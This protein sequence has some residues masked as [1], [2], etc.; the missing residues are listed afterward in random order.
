MSA[1]KHL[2]TM[3][4]EQLPLVA[5][6]P[7]LVGPKAPLPVAPMGVAAH[8][9]GSAE[10]PKAAA[11]AKAAPAAKPA[12]PKVVLA[13]PDGVPDYWAEAC[14]QLMR[15]DRVLKRLIP[16]LSAQAMLPRAQCRDEAFATLA[17]S[18]VGQ[19]IAA[20]SAKT[21]WNK[22]AK[23]P[24]EMTPE[25]VLKLKV[26]DMRAAGLSARKVDYLVDLAL[27]FTE[28]R[29]R[30]DEWAGMSDEAIVAEL[31]AIR[32]LSR[33]TA[34]NFLIYYLARPNVLPLDDAGLIQGI[35]LNYFSGDPVS[36]SDAREVA[37]A[38]KPWCT[39]A[40]WYIWRSLE[41]QPVAG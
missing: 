6:L 3:E 40:T 16:A 36:R 37:E 25:L 30:M 33:W 34:E 12:A 15:R 5:D 41:A 8:A 38:W 14:R 27:H 1:V 39:V 20:K 4:Y 10:A 7:V 29:L 32:G 35:S 28:N 26:D 24:A 22:F 13:L 17:R 18:I 11:A 23:L 31:M 21:L 9:E 19:Q 2:D